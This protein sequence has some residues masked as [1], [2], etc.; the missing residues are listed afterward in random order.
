MVAVSQPNDIGIP[1]E[2]IPLQLWRVL[3]TSG[4]TSFAPGQKASA[5][6][7]SITP[8]N[9]ISRR[10]SLLAPPVPFPTTKMVK[11]SGIVSRRTNRA[12]PKTCVNDLSG[13]ERYHRGRIAWEKCFSPRPNAAHASFLPSFPVACATLQLGPGAHGFLQLGGYHRRH[14]A[15]TLRLLRTSDERQKITFTKWSLDSYPRE[16]I[17]QSYLGQ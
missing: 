3:Y 4:R 9:L 10:V 2:E 13:C 12:P 7:I 17:C 11:T 1:I 5:A 8:L 14:S 16:S 6:L 15:C